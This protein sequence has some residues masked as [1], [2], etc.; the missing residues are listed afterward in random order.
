MKNIFLALFVFL[1]S[2]SIVAQSV[3]RVHQRTE[4][5]KGQRAL[6]DGDY[7]LH[8]YFN[9]LF[10][11][12]TPGCS[13][14]VEK[15]G[16]TI[17][18]RA[19]GASRLLANK[20]SKSQPLLNTPN[21]RMRVASVSK[22]ILAM[23]TLIL[24]DRLLQE[25]GQDLLEL[26]LGEIYPSKLKNSLLARIT[27]RQIL[28]HTSGLKREPASI[29]TSESDFPSLMAKSPGSW[30]S[31][32]QPG[33]KYSYS[34]VGYMLLGDIIRQKSGMDWK[35]FVRRNIFVPLQM[36]NSSFEDPVPLI[37]KGAVAQGYEASEDSFTP[38]SIDISR[39]NLLGS[40]GLISTTQ[41]LSKLTSI[42]RSREL[43]SESS[44]KA[45][46]KPNRASMRANDPYGLGWNVS[47]NNQNLILEHSG[48]GY[49]SST[50]IKV[51]DNQ[52]PDCKMGISILCNFEE[53]TLENFTVDSAAT[54]IQKVFCP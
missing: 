25:T 53:D 31:Q 30:I 14:S 5:N 15:D 24:R 44:W 50:L 7:M 48:A 9:K 40:G 52:K 41:D 43:L 32:N 12:T 4:A 22:P 28:H 47:T 37:E 1:I 13:F 3:E 23:A 54:R 45:L 46:L 38:Q 49:G 34:N 19:Y 51:I 26:N 21:R 29:P 8:Q 42:V 20:E 35:E 27:V 18:S 16:I 11:K 36:K 33:S 10:S 17:F 6:A 39:R 2:G